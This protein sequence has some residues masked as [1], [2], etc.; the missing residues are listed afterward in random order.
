MQGNFGVCRQ[1]LAFII[2][3]VS[4]STGPD[5][6]VASASE[7]PSL[8]IVAN[9]GVGPT[10][11]VAIVGERAYSI[12]RGSLRVLDISK[13]RFP[14]VLGKLAGLGNTRQLVVR[15]GV[16]YIGSR[17]ICPNVHPS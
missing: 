11:D 1:W 15:N 4:L 9:A 14:K 5:P 12:G 2:L 13:P 6:I 16:A 10:I 3:A 8:P 7:P 17:E